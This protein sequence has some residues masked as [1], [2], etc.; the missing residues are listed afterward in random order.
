[1]MT[2][3]ETKSTVTENE[4]MADVPPDTGAPGVLPQPDASQ[5]VELEPLTAEQ[6]D[7]LKAKAAKSDEHWERLLRMSADFEN[8]KKRAARERLDAIKFANESLLSKLIPILDNFDM[9]V[10]AANGTQENV[11]E[12]IKTGVQMIHGQLK[13]VL[14]ESGVEEIDATDKPFDPVWHEAVSQ[15]ESADFPEGSVL[16]QIRKGYKLKERL[17]R[18]ASVVVAKKTVQ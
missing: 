12:S 4:A 17:I 1:M 16:Q 7:E 8:F 10:T 14:T 9:A 18:P 6:L 15:Q 5:G 13:A 11:L 2:N 3:D